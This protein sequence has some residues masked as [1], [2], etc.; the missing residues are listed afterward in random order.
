MSERLRAL[1]DVDDV[2]A[3]SRQEQLASLKREDPELVES[4]ALL[5]DNPL[6]SAFEVSLGEVGVSRVAQWLS[7]AQPLADWADARKPA[8]VQAILQAQFYA[9]LLDLAPGLVCLGAALMLAGVWSSGRAGLR[10][11]RRATL[12]SLGGRGGA[13]P[14]PGPYCL[15]VLPMRAVSPWWGGRRP[16]R[17]YSH[18]RRGRRGVGVVRAARVTTLVLAVLLAA[19]GAWAQKGSAQAKK[20][21]LGDIQRELESTPR[22]RRLLKLEQSSTK[23]C[24]R[25]N[26]ARARS[27]AAWRIS[28]GICAR[29]SRKSWNLRRG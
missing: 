28:S 6:T 27:G 23:S 7:Q 22:D 20:R 14:P 25:F 10:T 17:G 12:E 19:T 8:Q 5:G 13:A 11:A 26:P 18:R 15:M 21:E 4:V 1:P 24:R 3:V 9:R 16:H 2:R 29:P